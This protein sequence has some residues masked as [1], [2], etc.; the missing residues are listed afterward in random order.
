MEEADVWL[1]EYSEMH[2]KAIN[3]EYNTTVIIWPLNF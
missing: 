3:F 2:A 1:Q